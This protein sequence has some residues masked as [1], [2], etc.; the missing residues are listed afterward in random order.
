MS[1]F[2]RGLG[3]I[4]VIFSL[5]GCK[6]LD[7]SN[8]EMNIDSEVSE[9]FE[10]DRAVLKSFDELANESD[11]DSLTEYVR[12]NIE[13]M[14][15]IGADSLVERL[16]QELVKDES[17]VDY[18]EILEEYENY[19]S[20]SYRDYLSLIREEYIQNLE[21]ENVLL[22]EWDEVGDRILNHERYLEQHLVSDY[23]E[24]VKD[25]YY[26]L[27][28]VYIYGLNNT[29]IA[30]EN[31]Y[32]IEA[33]KESYESFINLENNSKFKEVLSEYVEILKENEW[34]FSNERVTEFL[35]EQYEE[36]RELW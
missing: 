18:A 3:I 19:I 36:L 33:L 13:D 8:L 30:D 28:S 12:A 2:I 26:Y 21:R 1:Y 11:V 29:L 25:R 23:Y 9:I 10:E 22:I 14:T 6:S 35:V 32:I 34:N 31:G 7:L 27:I 4:I 15:V 16:I 17:N 5:V 20:D 24:Q